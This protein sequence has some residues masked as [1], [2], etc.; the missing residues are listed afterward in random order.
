MTAPMKVL[1]VANRTADSDEVHAALVSDLGFECGAGPGIMRTAA[2][3]DLQAQGC[4]TYHRARDD[5][6]ATL[7]DAKALVEEI[8]SAYDELTSGVSAKRLDAA[9]DEIQEA[10]DQLSSVL[11]VPGGSAEVLF[12]QV[13]AAMGGHHLAVANFL[14][15]QHGA[16]DEELDVAR[17]RV[18]AAQAQLDALDIQLSKLALTAPW[19]G[20]ILTRSAEVGQMALPGA[21][22]IAVGR[23]D[24]LE[25]T[26][27]LPE[28]KFGL[29][30]PTMRIVM[31]VTLGRDEQAFVLKT[32]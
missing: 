8:Q 2:Q 1:V 14:A 30:A 31:G 18:E 5:A 25:L 29:A 26:V 28:E 20:V 3:G 21:T 12:A 19:D 24:Q 6:Q 13:D 11:V 17:A 32:G 16:R 7:E 4:L 22:L 27:Y 15:L 23:L 9:W 10:Q